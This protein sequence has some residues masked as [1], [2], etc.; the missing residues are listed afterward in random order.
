[1]RIQ[2]PTLKHLLHTLPGSVHQLGFGEDLLYLYL[3]T[4]AAYVLFPEY[5]LEAGVL[6]EAVC[7]VVEDLLLALGVWSFECAA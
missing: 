1:M 3:G 4:V 2:L 7:Y 5:L 6:I